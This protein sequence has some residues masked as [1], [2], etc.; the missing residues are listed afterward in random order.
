MQELGGKGGS[1]IVS[2]LPDTINELTPLQQRWLTAFIETGGDP[3]Q[4]AKDAGYSDSSAR[5]IL[6]ANLRNP[7]IQRIFHQHVSYHLHRHAPAAVATLVALMSQSRSDKVKLDAA[8]ALLDRAGFRPV[9]RH[10]V[11]VQGDLR[12]SIDL[13][14]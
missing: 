14:D 13:G 8:I 7:L 2:K 11:A 3:V 12:V 1:S 9:E 4:A 10:Q 5:N 6:S